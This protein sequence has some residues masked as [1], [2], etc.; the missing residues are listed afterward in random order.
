MDLRH[1]RPFR[2]CLL[3]VTML[4]ALAGIGP[5]F[6]EADWMRTLLTTQI[7]RDTQRALLIDGRTR[8]VLLPRPALLLSNTR[9]T[10]P[11]NRTVFARTDQVKITLAPWPLL[12][13]KLE[14]EAI[15]FENPQLKIE[16]HADG[17]YNFD[18]LLR[19]HDPNNKLQFA[20]NRLNFT[21]A[22][23]DYRDQF[24]GESAELGPLDFTMD[25]LADPSKGRLDID[26]RLLLGTAQAP[27]WQ[28]RVK[29]TAAMRY[30][31]DERRILVAGLN[32]ALTQD[33][34]SRPGVDLKNVE[35]SAVGNLVYGWQPLRLTGGD[36]KLSGSGQRADQQWQGEINIPEI[37]YT[38][39]LLGLYRMGVKVDMKSHTAQF[40]ANVALPALSATPQ[41]TMHADDAALNVRLQTPHQLLQLNF[42]SPLDMHSGTL[43]RMPA[44]KLDGLYAH[45]ALPRGAIPLSLTGDALL[46]LRNESLQVTS[47][48]EL[49]HSHLA[50]SFNLDDFVKPRYRVQ[51]D[52]AKLDLSPYLPAVAEGAKSVKDDTALDLGFLNTLNAQ[53]EVQIGELVMQK[54]HVDDLSM[55][56]DAHDRKLTL[57]PLS[58]TLYE[59]QL[60]GRLEVDASNKTPAWRVTQKLTNMNVNTL[61]ADVLDTS[62]FEGR[63]H[64]DLDIS[65]VGDRPSDLKRTAGGNVRVLLNKGAIRGIDI[66]ALLRTAS[67]QLKALQGSQTQLLNLD[68]RTRFSELNA[69]MQLKHGL[70]SNSDLNVSAGVLQLKGGGTLNLS[71][72][73]VDYKLSASA[74]PKVPELKGLVGLTLP[75]T[76][77]GT[78]DAPQYKI[79]YAN[80]KDQILARQK[81]EQAPKK[82]PAKAKPADKK[83]TPKKAAKKK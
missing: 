29:A 18:D 53:G 51:F 27:I 13:G 47:A 66:E 17:S 14:I 36:L 32:L 26:G 43:A 70:A 63:G 60:A 80:L 41:G 11:G 39:N 25:N 71:D 6:F 4:V 73:A 74:N 79:D 76:L 52:L 37:R 20:L 8:V 7:E 65:A 2:L 58:A 12:H 44:Y 59:G 83:A 78:L 19:P 1:S 46:D 3:L 62:R 77:A 81:A 10:E 69:T 42:K 33:G 54:L 30:H 9:L 72:N 34:A 22:R 82:T 57:D 23:F 40:N 21:G 56:L 48:G 64:L 55:K 75:I 28:G 68:A 31:Q 24:L 61:L 49:D 67:Q 45:K 5:Y 35:V 16:R 50:A 15:D 38:Q